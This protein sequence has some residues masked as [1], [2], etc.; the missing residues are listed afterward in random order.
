LLK[1]KQNDQLH[2]NMLAQTL[3]MFSHF[4]RA[5]HP[6]VTG[7]LEASQ[8]VETLRRNN[9]DFATF[10]DVSERQQRA[11]LN[12]L[13]ILPVQRLP[14]YEL[15]LVD[16]CAE[17]AADD[18]SLP[19]FQQALGRIK[20]V[21]RDINDSF[22]A[23]DGNTLLRI[24]RS[25]DAKLNLMS[26]PRHLVREGDLVVVHRAATNCLCSSGLTSSTRF[27]FFLFNDALMYAAVPSCW[28]WRRRTYA[29]KRVL[30]LTRL[31]IDKCGDDD[32]AD[33]DD[34][35]FV[36]GIDLVGGIGVNL[37]QNGGGV[38]GGVGG[39][40]GVDKRRQ[41]GRSI[42]SRAP[43]RSQ[44]QL[45][46]ERRFDYFDA[47]SNNADRTRRG[48]ESAQ[49]TATAADAE[50]SNSVD[51]DDEAVR[52]CVR[53]TTPQAKHSWIASL[54]ATASVV[55]TLADTRRRA[56]LARTHHTIY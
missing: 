9:G 11:R 16:L 40:G 27:R 35:T 19:D 47:V 50:I 20:A 52:L 54:N 26:S 12:A 29:F 4:F 13:L 53:A 45:M 7:A 8:R 49:N 46:A 51:D 5:Y 56:M 3:A 21:T 37:V 1:L 39:G 28:S 55:R 38:G 44:E 10:C 32:A 14:R 41:R 2:T 15:L 17:T 36:I 25:L 34:C 48:S 33:D 24:Q 31:Y 22:R 23:R 6:Y 30:R 43:S 42:S 18:E